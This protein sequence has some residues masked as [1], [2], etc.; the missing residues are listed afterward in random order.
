MMNNNK[1][2]DLSCIELINENV[3]PNT[4]IVHVSVDTQEQQVTFD[5][6]ANQVSAAEIE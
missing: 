4:G 6:D 5:Y 2:E 1:Q 3:K